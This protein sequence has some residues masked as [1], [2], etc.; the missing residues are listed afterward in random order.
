M[1]IK[2]AQQVHVIGLNHFIPELMSAEMISG[3]TYPQ[4]WSVVQLVTLVSSSL[5]LL[6]TCV[7]YGLIRKMAGM[8]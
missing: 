7:H 3:S 5:S 8:H 4:R 6:V 1:Y 2:D